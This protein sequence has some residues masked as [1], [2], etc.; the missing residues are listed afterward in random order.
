MRL[1]HELA[2]FKT[3]EPFAEQQQFIL[4]VD[5]G[6]LRLKTFGLL[7]GVRYEERNVAPQEL[8]VQLSTTTPFVPQNTINEFEELIN[9]PQVSERDIHRFLVQ[10]PYFLLGDDYFALHSELVLDRADKG[11]LVPDFF[12][13][14]VNRN[15]VD[16]IDLKKP[17]EQLIV[18]SKNRRGFSAAVNYAVYQLREYRD[19]FD[20][21][22]RRKEFS[23]RYG[24]EA[25]MPKIAVII[26]RNP[27]GYGYEEL[28]RARRSVIDANII[29]YDDVLDRAR[30]R[31][32]IVAPAAK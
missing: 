23:R 7:D 12:A 19:Y 31:S 24:L 15:Y 32:I 14:L 2:R 9:W 11:P 20:N 4:T 25:W 13:E 5:Q 22:R 21:S 8:V 3:L 28:I 18:G 30:R 26:G 16:I 29:T 10:R 1:R 6:R 17:N 27:T